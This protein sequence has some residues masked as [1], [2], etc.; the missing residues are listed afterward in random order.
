MADAAEKPKM[1]FKSRKRK[2]TMRK[3]EVRRASSAPGGVA[4]VCELGCCP[5]KACLPRG[6]D[7]RTATS[8]ASHAAPALRAA[9]RLEPQCV[10]FDR[11]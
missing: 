10:L 1:V 8:F 9:G 7:G 6:G 11:A 4:L 5:G 3:R 2:N